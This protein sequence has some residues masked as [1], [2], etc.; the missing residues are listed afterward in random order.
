MVNIVLT[1]R[2][3]KIVAY[4]RHSF[5]FKTCKCCDS[6]LHSISEDH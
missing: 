5:S 3:A 1:D 2:V 6:D 4:V